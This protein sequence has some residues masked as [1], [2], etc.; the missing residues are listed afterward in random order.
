MTI[1]LLATLHRVVLLHVSSLGYHEE[2]FDRKEKA[3]APPLRVMP[4]PTTFP[5]FGQI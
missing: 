3:D 5:G 4:Y 1:T 2:V